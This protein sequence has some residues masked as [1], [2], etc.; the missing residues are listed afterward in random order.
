VPRR[1][2][3]FSAPH[4]REYTSRL[5]FD[6]GVQRGFEDWQVDVARDVF[7]GPDVAREVWLLVPEGNGKTTLVAALALYGLDFAPN[8]WIPVGASS[9]DQA[10]ILYTQAK[11]FVQSTPGLERRFE[12]FDGYREIRSLRDADRRGRFGPAGRGIVVCPWDPDTNDGTIPYPYAIVDELHRH[13]DLTLYRLWKGKL[14]KRGAQ[15]VTISTAGEPG[16]EFEDNRDLIRQRA[17][18][19]RRRHGGVR[20]EGGHLVMHEYMLEDVEQC[21][22]PAKVAAVNPLPAITADTV[23]EDLASP[24]F[25]IGD[26]K[27]L[28]CNIPARSAFAAI[29][30]EEWAAAGTSLDRI[31][32]GERIDCGLDF[33]WKWDTTAIAPIWNAG[34]YWLL[35]EAEVI[36]PPRDGTS[37]HP[38]RV[39]ERFTQV[40]E[41][42]PIEV[43]VCDI[44][45]GEDIAAWLEDELGVRVIVRGQETR[46]KVEDYKAFMRG[47]RNGTLRRVAHCPRLTRHSM[48]A[49]Q[50]RL[51][52]GDFRFDRPVSSRTAKLQD[53]RVIDALDAAGM[54]HTV[55][56]TSAG[57]E[58]VYQER[59]LVVLS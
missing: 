25:D 54:V 51:P 8:P 15:I 17:A 1:S 11:S 20:F 58:S 5:V 34:E 29:T 18:K 45:N 7:R 23:A 36:T 21:M 53:R 31:P 47:L 49:V 59:E 19:R 33:G 37:L 43:V 56:N 38:D 32:E 9:R 44:T 40:H 42:T 52:G 6:D 55:V 30:D 57:E 27:R 16:S 13:E 28:K 24:T 39:K 10:R 2:R 46:S 22:D 4:F 48:N 41:R 14:R 12:C 35:D 26:H 50:R 3:P